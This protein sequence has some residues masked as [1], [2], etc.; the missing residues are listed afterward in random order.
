MI[1]PALETE[2]VKAHFDPSQGISYIQYSGDVDGNDTRQVYSWVRELLTV[3]GDN[4][5][6]GVIFDFREVTH[7]ATD[8]M[9]ATRRE[10][11]K[12]NTER[13]NSNHPIALIVRTLYQEKLVEVTAR[14][15]SDSDR[16]QIVYSMEEAMA[17][18]HGWHKQRK[19]AQGSEIA[20][21][22]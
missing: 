17:F 7:F 6:Y 14:V 10:T 18:I 3:I 19:P 20:R 22:D 12:I 4:A 21:T 11:K 2:R 1:L 13:D 9:A 15:S 5:T 16:K 8:N